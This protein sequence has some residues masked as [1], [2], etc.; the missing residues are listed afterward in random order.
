MTSKWS[1]IPAEKNVKSDSESLLAEAISK[2]DV[3]DYY[4]FIATQQV[5]SI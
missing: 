1:I 3:L 4:N 2:S 5:L